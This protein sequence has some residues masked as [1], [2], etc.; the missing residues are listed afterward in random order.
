MSRKR[1]F[2]LY[3]DLNISARSRG[4]HGIRNNFEIQSHNGPLRSA[5][6]DD[7]YSAARKILL[8]THIFVA[9]EKHI[10][11]GALSFR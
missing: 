2:L 8:I 10:E 4:V 6:H 11:T 9:G 5:K 3:L 1:L 7:G